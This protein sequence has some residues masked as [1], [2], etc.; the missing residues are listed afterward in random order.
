MQP[1]KDECM[2]NSRSDFIACVVYFCPLYA[3]S[4]IYIQYKTKQKYIITMRCIL[5]VHCAYTSW[6]SNYE[7]IP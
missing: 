4:K 1:E 6:P 2:E 7:Q 3:K 5:F